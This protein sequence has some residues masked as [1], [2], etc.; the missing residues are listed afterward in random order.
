[1]VPLSAAAC[2]PPRDALIGPHL[3]FDDTRARAMAR[4]PAALDPVCRL[5][6]IVRG[7]RPQPR[8][9]SDAPTAGVPGQER[10]VDEVLRLVPQVIRYFQRFDC[11]ASSSFGVSVLSGSRIPPAC[12]R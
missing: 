4:V 1:M 5:I 7:G 3:V 12:P 10:L 11:P 9:S 8:S 2:T 6:L